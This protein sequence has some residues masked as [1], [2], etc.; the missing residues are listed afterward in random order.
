MKLSKIYSNN[1]KFKTITF[2]EGFNVIY[3]DVDNEIDETTGKVH[4]HNI[5]KTSLVNLIDFLLLK[6]ENKDTFFGK[7]KDIFSGWIFYLEIK[8]NNGKYLT[9]RRAVDQNSRI[10]FKEH[11]SRDQD[12]TRENSWDFDDLSINTTD[13]MQNPKHILEKRYLCFEINTK[14]K[15][16]RFLAYLLRNQNDYQDVFKLNK[17]RGKDLYWKPVV[18]ELLGF[19]SSSLQEK[20]ALDDDIKEEKSHI[21][22][23]QSKHD[24]D[25]EIYKIKAAIEAKEIEKKEIQ[26]NIDSFDFYQKEQNINF[27]LVKNVENEIA[28]LNKEEYLLN[29]N[30]E[31]INKSLDS[32]NKPSLKIGELEQLF[33]EVNIYFPNNLSKDYQDVLSFS[34]QITKEREKYLKEELK[35]LKDKQVTVIERLKALNYT[36]GDMLSILKEKDTFIKYRKF[37]EDLV[38]IE[39]EIYGYQSKLEHAKTIENYQNSLEATKDKIKALV[40]SIKDE[41]D[42]DNSNFREIKKM[43]QDIYKKTFEYTALLVVEPNKSGNVKFDTSVLNKSKDLTGK[44]D[45]Y[46]STKVLCAS[47]VLAILIHYSSKSFYRFAY[48]DGI[49]ESWGDNHKIQFIKLLREYCERYKIQYIISLIKSDVPKGFNFECNEIVR[50]LSKHDE[51]FGFEF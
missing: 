8:L 37:Q 48:H 29:H 32:E 18:F 36:R 6:E 12:F 5:G 31:Q 23:L 39:S 15:F 2:N 20:Y 44:G 33:N 1:S 42:K 13:E 9:I 41:I 4:E 10:S 25:N 14:F 22:K 16:R 30:I 27:D 46:T 7:Y 28:Q 45:G 40:S 50:T 3:G 19:D 17:H 35:E 49:L 51:L 47:F 11:F 43:F 34:S 21:K 26:Q 38:R 24:S